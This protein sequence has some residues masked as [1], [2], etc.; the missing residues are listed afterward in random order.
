[1][2]VLAGIQ[3]PGILGVMDET[4]RL[5]LHTPGI[6]GVMDET[7]RLGLHTPHGGY[8]SKPVDEDVAGALS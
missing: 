3:R 6:L 7:H 8:W 5:G 4:H 2:H 1:M